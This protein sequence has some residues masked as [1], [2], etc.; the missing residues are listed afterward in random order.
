MPKSVPNAVI[1]FAEARA[2]GLSWSAAAREAGWSLDGLHRWIRRNQVAWYRELF[3]ARRDAR[4]SACDEAV[5]MLRVQ[6]R[7]EEAKTKLAAASAVAKHFANSKPAMRSAN[8][9]N[10][11]SDIDRLVCNMTDSEL[12]KLDQELD[13]IEE[14]VRV[15]SG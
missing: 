13:A 4:D 2:A 10:A 5:A 12:T 15:D 7:N 8:N 9:S 11:T 1:K 14:D 3:R 6:L